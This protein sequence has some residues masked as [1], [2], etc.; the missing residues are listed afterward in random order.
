MNFMFEFHSLSRSENEIYLSSYISCK[1]GILVAADILPFVPH[2]VKNTFAYSSDTLLQ[3]S[4][5]YKLYR[6]ALTPVNNSQ[7][8]LKLEILGKLRLVTFYKATT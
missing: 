8:L 7:L 1:T 3:L 5:I 6:Q 4:V 2:I